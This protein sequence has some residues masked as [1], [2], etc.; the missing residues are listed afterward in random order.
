MANVINDYLYETGAVKL[1]TRD[2]IIYKKE[3][4][5]DKDHLEMEFEHN[6]SLRDWEKNKQHEEIE[7]TEAFLAEMS[8]KKSLEEKE[9]DR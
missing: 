2:F 8:N 1:V 9:E 6:K 4:L 5:Y 3:W 7:A